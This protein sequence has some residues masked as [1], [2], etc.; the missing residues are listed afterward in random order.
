MKKKERD[1]LKLKTINELEALVKELENSLFKIKLEKAQN[2]LK[3][4]RSIFWSRKKIAFILTVMNEKE[5]EKV[6]TKKQ[7]E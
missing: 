3:N 5:A 1:E 7:E 2:K 4:L 6:Q